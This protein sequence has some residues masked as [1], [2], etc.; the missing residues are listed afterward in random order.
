MNIVTESVD[1]AGPPPVSRYGSSKIWAAPMNE[2][3]T[4]KAVTGFSAGRG[5]VVKVRRR[6]APARAARLVQLPRHVLESGQEE[7]RE[8]AGPVRSPSHR[9]RRVSSASW[10][11]RT[12]FASA[13]K[14]A[15]PRW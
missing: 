3:T 13:S 5:T 14:K 6:P 15:P 4:T 10:E 9:K 12:R 8:V 2:V 1:T 7:H 11:S